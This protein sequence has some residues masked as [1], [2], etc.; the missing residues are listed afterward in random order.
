MSVN[1]REREISVCDFFLFVMCAVM[2]EDVMCRYGTREREYIVY[3]GNNNK[4]NNN[5]NNININLLDRHT[6]GLVGDAEQADQRV[7]AADGAHGPQ[8]VERER[9]ERRQPVP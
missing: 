3:Q 4:T 8:R 7:F 2:D 9:R 1:E 5:R 6:H